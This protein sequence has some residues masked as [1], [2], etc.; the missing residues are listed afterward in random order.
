MCADSN[1]MK[2]YVRL[3]EN[4]SRHN[5]GRREVVLA[6][7]KCHVCMIDKEYFTEKKID[8]GRGQDVIG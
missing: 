5:R 4:C 7:F 2:I 3:C 8:I 1:F 6:F